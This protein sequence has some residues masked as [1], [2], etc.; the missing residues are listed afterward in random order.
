MSTVEKLKLMVRKQFWSNR[1]PTQICYNILTQSLF[2]SDISVKG[3]DYVVEE[4]KLFRILASLS[5]SIFTKQ[6]TEEHVSV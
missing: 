2:K 5:L 6:I 3:S 1:C 4:K